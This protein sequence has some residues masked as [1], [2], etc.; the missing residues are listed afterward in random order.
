[1]FWLVRFSLPGWFNRGYHSYRDV[2]RDGLFVFDFVD[3]GFAREPAG[4]THTWLDS[5]RAAGCQCSGLRNQTALSVR[6]LGQPRAINA[7]LSATVT[8]PGGCRIFYAVLRMDEWRTCG[9][10][11]RWP[12]ASG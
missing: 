12:A 1:M 9:R 3:A 10:P 4:Y 8:M 5:D 7:N 2:F 6:L 11:R